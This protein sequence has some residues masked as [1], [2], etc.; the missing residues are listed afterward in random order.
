MM[1]E[2]FALDGVRD[3]PQVCSMDILYRRL[4]ARVA[5]DYRAELDGIV[6][7]RY[8]GGERDEKGSECDQSHRYVCTVRSD[9]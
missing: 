6:Q 1:V 2:V 9:L 4:R 7:K 8:Q 3:D 5:E